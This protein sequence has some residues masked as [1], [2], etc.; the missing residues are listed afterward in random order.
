MTGQ[1]FIG[2]WKIANVIIQM[3]WYLKIGYTK[4]IVY[5]SYAIL[6]YSS[7]LRVG[8]AE[9]VIFKHKECGCLEEFVS[10]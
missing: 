1:F 7:P 4:Q 2:S 6:L 8:S 10:L 9:A 5:S 3:E